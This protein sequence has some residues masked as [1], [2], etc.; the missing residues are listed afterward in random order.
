M[1]ASHG[2]TLFDTAIGSC[3]I[4]WRGDTVVGVQLPEADAQATRA[5]LRRRFP[6]AGETLAPAR[7]RPVADALVRLLEGADSDLAAVPLDMSGVPEFHRRV[8][9]VV[10]AIPSGST[11]SYG[12]VAAQLGS[13]RAARAV[14]TAMTRNPYPLIVPCHRVLAAGGRI[15]GYSANGGLATK[16]RLLA[17]EGSSAA[18]TELRRRDDEAGLAF[19]PAAALAHL[20]TADPVLGR[21]ID[22]I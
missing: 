10:R 15:G 21:L 13:P 6:E 18:T 22:E 2:F 14:G 12:D 3:G 1:A 9:E 4:A 5:R 7:L 16:R 8:Y 19:D 17:I 11:L 20:R